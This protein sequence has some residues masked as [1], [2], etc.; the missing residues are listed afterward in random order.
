MLIMNKNEYFFIETEDELI[1]AY[2][3]Y[4]D[5]FY[6]SLEMELSNFRENEAYRRVIYKNSEGRIY[7]INY[8]N[9]AGF[10][11][12][13]YIPNP[14]KKNIIPN[15][16]KNNR[17]VGDKTFAL[18]LCSF[19]EDISISDACGEDELTY[20][21]GIAKKLLTYQHRTVS[22]D[23]EKEYFKNIKNNFKEYLEKNLI[24][25]DGYTF[26]DGDKVRL[27]SCMR[28]PQKSDDNNIT[29]SVDSVLAGGINPNRIFFKEESN[30]DKYVEDNLI[31]YSKK[32]LEKFL[33]DKAE[34]KKNQ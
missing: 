10:Q 8:V 3:S 18:R 6:Y 31:Q 7:L 17:I 29:F 25:E 13:A 28:N 21:R 1:D 27:F 32:D 33:N 34:I 16:I 23:S 30:K 22:E 14:I 4:G 24:T 19:L 12:A 26:Y 15:P 9:V 5:T 2:N 20:L 11:G